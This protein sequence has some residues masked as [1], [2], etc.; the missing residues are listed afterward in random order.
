[1][2]DQWSLIRA[3]L[4][5]FVAGSLMYLVFGPSVGNV[6]PS[7]PRADLLE[8]AAFSLAGALGGIAVA[9][10]RNRSV[11][12]RNVQFDQERK[13][14]LASRDNHAADGPK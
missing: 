7:K 10:G 6:G 3:A 9:F 13:I 4:L 5:G 1:M 14:L 11:R 12:R 8:F 2:Y